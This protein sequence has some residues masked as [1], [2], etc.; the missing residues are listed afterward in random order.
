MKQKVDMVEHVVRRA[1]QNRN[2]INQQRKNL[3][4][5]APGNDPAGPVS[6]PSQLEGISC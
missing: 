1:W 4:A 2:M 6:K 5:L 3:F